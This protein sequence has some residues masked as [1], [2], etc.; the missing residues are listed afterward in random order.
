MEESDRSASLLKTA[1][2][3]IP[4]SALLGDNI[5]IGIFSR[6]PARSATDAAPSPRFGLRWS[7]SVEPC[8]GWKG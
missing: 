2:S 4:I 3:L 5:H 6:L 8:R 1:R 7:C